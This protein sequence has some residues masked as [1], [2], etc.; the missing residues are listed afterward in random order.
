LKNYSINTFFNAFQVSCC[1]IQTKLAEQEEKNFT[2]PLAWC[3]NM[4]SLWLAQS[5]GIKNSRWNWIFLQPLYFASL[6]WNFLFGFMNYDI[7]L[8]NP[9]Y[10]FFLNINAY[11]KISLADFQANLITSFCIPSLFQRTQMGIEEMLWIFDAFQPVFVYFFQN[12][13]SLF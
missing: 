11:F 6:S 13:T 1:K 12:P 7:T 4:A 9:N 5:G 2:L 10:I 3:Y 8:R